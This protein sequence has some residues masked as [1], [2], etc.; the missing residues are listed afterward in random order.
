MVDLIMRL[1]LCIFVLYFFNIEGNFF[2]FIGT[3]IV[4]II[5]SV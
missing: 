5:G 1:F 2:D 3:G 4:F